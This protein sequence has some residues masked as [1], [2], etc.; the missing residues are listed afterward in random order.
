MPDLSHSPL[1]NRSAVAEIEELIFNLSHLVNSLRPYQ[2]REDL[3]T[4][5]QSQVDAKQRLI[6]DLRGACAE[7]AACTVEGD[8]LTN[9]AP[10]SAE[11]PPPQPS[12]ASR[13]ARDELARLA[14]PS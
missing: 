5:V 14:A 6:A 4:L 2:A 10:T 1:R 8:Y 11:P 12:A 13:S 7:F 3:I 9:L